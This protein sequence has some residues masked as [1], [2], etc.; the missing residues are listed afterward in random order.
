MEVIVD[1]DPETGRVEY[2]ERKVYTKISDEVDP[3][4]YFDVLPE[5]EEESDYTVEYMIVP[6]KTIRFKRFVGKENWSGFKYGVNLKHVKRTL[7]SNQIATRIIVKPNRNEFATD[8]FC[9]IQRADE[10]FIKENFIYDFSYYI[11]KKMLDYGQVLQDLYTDV[12][13][14][15]GYYRKLG[16]LN[17]END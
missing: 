6:K 10:N 3:Q 5:G 4:Q 15:L 17:K 14:N 7:D 1:H 8:G 16:R 11:N 9:T 12:G 13:S 2:E